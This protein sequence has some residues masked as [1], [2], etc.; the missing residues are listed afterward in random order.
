MNVD[1]LW[2]QANQLYDIG[3]YHAAAGV[4][5]NILVDHHDD[6]GTRALLAESLIGQFEYE[7]AETVAKDLLFDCPGWA[8]AH[9]ILGLI[10]TRKGWF[11]AARL[12]YE[13]VL[14]MEPDNPEAHG[15]LCFVYYMMR[16]Y[17]AAQAYGERAILLAPN[18]SSALSLLAGVYL[19]QNKHTLGMETYRKAISLNPMN[20]E[21][22]SNLL[23]A[24]ELYEGYSL[25]DIKA[26]RDEWNLVHAEKFYHARVTN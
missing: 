16:D 25:E 6:P 18:S 13:M 17:R 14:E 7:K 9:L 8:K 22:H 15:N 26:E 19:V 5:E 1:E 24:M 11:K 23:F 20:F 4:A 10:R 2:E 21:A 12:T 3:E